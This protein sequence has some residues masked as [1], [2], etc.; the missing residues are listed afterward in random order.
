MEPASRIA[1]ISRGPTADAYEATGVDDRVTAVQPGRPLGPDSMDVLASTRVLILGLSYPEAHVAAQ[2]MSGA[3]AL[4]VAA[5]LLNTR[6]AWDVSALRRRIHFHVLGKRP[7]ML[8]PFGDSVLRACD[9]FRPHI[10]LTTGISPVS[11]Q[12]LQQVRA[13][14]IVCANYL[15]DDPWNRKTGARFFWAALR[16]YDVVFSPRH[17]N[18]SDLVQHGCRA[19]EYLP[20]AYGPSLHFPEDAASAIERERFACDVAFIGGGDRQRVDLVEPVLREGFDTRLYGGFWDRFASTRPAHR[21]FV[22][23]REYRLAVGGARVNLCMGRASNRDGHAMRSF[24][25]PAIGACILA[26]DTAEHRDI[27]GDDGEC[28]WYYSDAD[29]M[30]RRLRELLAA[31]ESLRARLKRAALDRI[32][33][34]PNTYADRLR[35]MIVRCHEVAPPPPG[36]VPM[37]DDVRASAGREAN[38][39]QST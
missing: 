28:V 1:T 36:L 19:T 37:S 20:F 33:S 13:R 29:N 18:L 32:R 39:F 30:V 2:L 5:R 22:H 8:G 25:L 10:V 38:R 23:G 4:G 17:S 3:E 34:R 11:A 27:F 9:D 16:E 6:Q 15:T 12:V 14:G 35:Q 7:P 26:E 24:E 31:P 21:G